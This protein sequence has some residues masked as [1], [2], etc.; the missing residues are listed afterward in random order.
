MRRVLLHLCE[1]KRDLAARLLTIFTF[2]YEF[3]DLVPEVL[4]EDPFLHASLV[5]EAELDVACKLGSG[6]VLL[7]RV[8]K[9]VLGG[10]FCLF[11]EAQVALR[12]LVNLL[13]IALVPIA[14]VIIGVDLL[15]LVDNE[16]VVY[17]QTDSK[18]GNRP[19]ILHLEVDRCLIESQLDGFSTLV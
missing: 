3:F 12:G 15:N 16:E 19:P 9:K 8:P 11:C 14:N 6:V 7:A 1:I 13:D 5:E 18:V 4:K 10:V 2:V 17:F